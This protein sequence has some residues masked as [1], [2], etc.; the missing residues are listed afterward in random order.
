MKNG[1]TPYLRFNSG[2]GHCLTGEVRILPGDK[3]TMIVSN[4]GGHKLDLKGG[5][6]ILPYF[7]DAERYHQIKRG[8]EVLEVSYQK[9]SDCIEVCPCIDDL[10]A[11]RFIA[12]FL[13][14]SRLEIVNMD[15]GEKYE[16]PISSKRNNSWVLIPYNCFSVQPMSVLDDKISTDYI[17]RHLKEMGTLF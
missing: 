16:V 3:L 4:E 8:T 15:K 1:I 10:K 14:K 6:I 2:S 9:N 7:N 5:R 13:R 17:K 11:E 12:R